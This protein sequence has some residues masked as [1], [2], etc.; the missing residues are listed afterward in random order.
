MKLQRYNGNFAHCL[1][2]SGNQRFATAKEG[3]LYVILMLVKMELGFQKILMLLME[4]F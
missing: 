2:Q 4:E 3:M 1:K